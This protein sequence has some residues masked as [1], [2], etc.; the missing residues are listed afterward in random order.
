MRTTVTI[1]DDVLEAAMACADGMS[2]SEVINEA[3]RRF[4]RARRRREML[5]LRGTIEWEGDIDQ[6][7]GRV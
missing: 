4:A 2:R 7:R 3:L 6:L 5:A 1:E